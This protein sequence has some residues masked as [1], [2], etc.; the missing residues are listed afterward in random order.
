MTTW[1]S[2][3]S[4]WTPGCTTEQSNKKINCRLSDRPSWRQ[5]YI[6]TH[7]ENSTKI[8]KLISLGV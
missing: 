2:S 7:T 5:V 4:S 6:D 3:I 8:I 1:R